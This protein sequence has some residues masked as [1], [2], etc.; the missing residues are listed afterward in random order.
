MAPRLPAPRPPSPDTCD[1][2]QPCN[3]LC[4][5]SFE[6]P[7]LIADIGEITNV[8]M[9]CWRTFNPFM[10]SYTELWKG[11][12]V[13]SPSPHS[14]LQYARISQTNGVK[15]YQNFTAS[16]GMVLTISYW[17][18]SMNTETGYMVVS[19]GHANAGLSRSA[20]NDPTPVIF[21]TV[22]ATGNTWIQSTYSITIP[23]SVDSGYAIIFENAGSRNNFIDDVTITITAAAVSASSN[24]PVIQGA[25]INLFASTIP[26]V[27]YAWTG[28]L[29]FT[30]ALQNPTIP[31]A[32]LSMEGDYI[33]TTVDSNGCTSSSRTPV[34]VEQCSVTGTISSN[35]PLTAPAALNLFATGLGGTAP[36]TY[37]W[38]GPNGWSSI[39]QNPTINSTSSLNAGVYTVVITDTNGCVAI[40]TIAVFIVVLPCYIVTNC[41]LTN[42]LT[43]PFITSSDLSNQVGMSIRFCN[44]TSI[45]PDGCYCAT[46][47]LGTDCVGAQPHDL[48]IIN[49]YTTCEECRP[50]CYFLTDCMGIATPILVSDNLLTYVGK[51]IQL[52][53][54]ATCWTVTAANSCTDSVCVETVATSFDTCELC[55]PP[56]IPIPLE[57]LYTR[58]VKPGY[59]TPGCSTEY[60]ERV[61]CNFAEAIYDQMIKLRYGITTC[62]DLDFNKWI[63]KKEELELRALYDP[64]MCETILPELPEE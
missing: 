12:I 64:E 20:L 17:H 19:L 7:I 32:T 22:T 28:P 1:T 6:C 47:S 29:G 33:V 53:G 2:I 58:S 24:S 16:V 34:I 38:S 10:S 45:W 5:T 42:L 35:G 11:G 43:A 3:L 4:N 40:L 41:D 14:G 56:V 37:N 30:S 50:K 8:N 55:L 46:V 52:T 61:N 21:G 57:P 18:A 60:T 36:Y 62:C 13:G 26:G 44:S 39:I 51:V 63:L 27:T 23:A 31:G 54:C 48:Q 49:H 9:P 25:T 59:N 15:L